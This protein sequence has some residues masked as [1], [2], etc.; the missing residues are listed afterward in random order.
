[1]PYPSAGQAGPPPQPGQTP[2]R[3]GAPQPGQMP[4][5]GGAR[6]PGPPP[7][8]SGTPRPAAM[9][10]PGGAG[11][12]GPPAQ[13]GQMP[14]HGGARQ[15]GPP[16]PGQT[17]PQTA[18]TSQT[19]AMHQPGGT[20]QRDTDPTGRRAEAAFEDTQ[21]MLAAQAAGGRPPG[22]GPGETGRSRRARGVRGAGTPM[23][24][25]GP[26]GPAGGG[27][28]DGE[29]E[30]EP[31]KR[32]W[33]RFV[34]S[35][36]IVMA[37][38]V[39]LAAGVFG[40]IAVAYAN[41]PVPTG[42]QA[43]VDDQG[44]VIYYADG[45]TAIARLGVKRTP[46]EINQV[47]A[48]VVDA[49]IALENRDFRT[50][51]GI[52]LTGMMRSFWS[53]A[54]GAQVQ[55]ASTITQ[56]MARGYYDGLSKEVSIQRKIKEIFVAVKI[57]K[58]LSKDEILKRYLNA[59]YFGRG[60][61]G[62]GAAAQAFFGKPIGKLTPP[63]GAY[64]AGRI[65]NPSTFDIQE[66]S[67]NFAA[68]KERYNAALKYMVES[69]PTAY[70]KYAGAKFEDLKFAKIKTDKSYDGLKGYMLNIVFRELEKR[71]ISQDDLKTK[72]LKIYTTFDKK[73]MET[74]KSAVN[75]RTASLD[76]T[77]HATVASVNPKN[78]RVVAFYSG[79]DYTQDYNNRAFTSTKQAASAFKPYV[80]AA[81]LEN[82]WSLNSY[83]DGMSTIDMPGTTTI[84][85][86]HAAPYGPITTEKAL[87]D[88]VN[89]VF[90]QMGDKVGLKEVARIAKEAG[91][92]EEAKRNPS[93][94][95][96]NGVD[97]AVD[98]QKFQVTIGSASVT[99][100]EQA[101]GYSIFANAGKHVDWHTVIKVVDAKTGLVVLPEQA[102]E[103]QVI[104]ADAAADAVV[105]LQEVV[106]SGTGTAANFG[107]RPVAGKTGTN[108]NNKDAWFVGFT[109]QLVTAVGMF[110]DV[111]YDKTG[112]RALK[113]DKH[114]LP[115]AK[116]KGVLWKEEPM[117]S[118]IG[119]GGTPTQIWHDYM[120]IVTAK[121]KVEQF[122]PPSH[123]G[124]TNNLVT[125]KPT[126]S[127][128]PTAEDPFTPDGG[129]GGG[130][131]E[132]PDDGGFGTG[133]GSGDGGDQMDR[134]PGEE[135][136]PGD[137]S[138]DNRGG[139]GD[140]SPNGEF[141][142]GAAPGAATGPNPQPSGQRP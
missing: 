60:A 99:A 83:V 118:F 37:S 79:D 116:I 87:A 124:V 55:G 95:G 26:G 67:G 93:Y 96:K 47:P 4:Q 109:P 62:I 51:S 13:P 44:S 91:V 28:G 139:G 125:P 57:N 127:P 38:F 138:C 2:S 136:L 24:S 133:D 59:I 85:N 40:M 131:N 45:K 71:G 101:A 12:A 102:V 111:P 39:V 86:S 33:R 117:P 21:A 17:P 121:D 31:D 1:M 72:G 25:G 70:G 97:Y 80:L 9:P 107:V 20:R 76:P 78:G 130:G 134:P 84:K 140:G 112:K 11:Q 10:Y 126:P 68:T 65:Q 50:D 48:G 94:Q 46:V 92:G 19:T 54:T 27:P 6:Q 36:K 61:N 34:P 56:Q 42:V 123:T 52:D 89:T 88:S 98:E 120:Q 35:W 115:N 58:T 16:Q 22:S 8:T 90:V 64:L 41:T 15:A 132:W 53:T 32:G 30:D 18:A 137:G 29:D 73:M 110:K 23:G 129:D 108:D 14:P 103:R 114:G 128:T 69:N 100:V 142:G 119:G 3:G 82:G 43:D 105:A 135:C 106:K 77:I 104:S 7:Q 113:V 74:A 63:E 141:G 122:P 81:W 5:Y 49:V 66:Q 75:A